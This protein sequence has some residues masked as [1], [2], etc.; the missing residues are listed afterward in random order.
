MHKAELWLPVDPQYNDSR[1]PI[2][3]Q[4]FILSENEEGTPI[5]TPDQTSIGLNINGNYDAANQAY[6]FNISQ[7]FQQMLNGSFPSDRLYVVAS[8]AGISLQG[9]VLNG[10]EMQNEPGDTT[11]LKPNA[12]ILVT[13][14]E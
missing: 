11:S 3:T 2:P 8:R 14:S 6:R 5:S 9:V 13:W 1:Y 4:L 12:R 10:P 7:T